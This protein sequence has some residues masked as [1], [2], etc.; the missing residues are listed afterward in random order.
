MGIGFWLCDVFLYIPHHSYFGAADGTN[1]VS[2]APAQAWNEPCLKYL[3]FIDFTNKFPPETSRPGRIRLP[4][5]S[6]QTGFSSQ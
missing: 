3:G 5:E 1:L 2:G 4:A 6:Q